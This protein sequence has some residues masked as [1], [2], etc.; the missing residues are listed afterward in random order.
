MSPYQ[1]A[2]EEGS[3]RV[4]MP[5]S[6]QLVFERFDVPWTDYVG[7][8]A[9]IAPTEEKAEEVKAPAVEGLEFAKAASAG[10]INDWFWNLPADRFELHPDWIHRLELSMAPD[11]VAGFEACIEP[12]DLPRVRRTIR[13][14][15]A[16]GARSFVVRFSLCST[17]G[18]VLP[19]ECFGQVLRSSEGGEPE[20]LGGRLRPLTGGWEST[21]VP[22][23]PVAAELPSSGNPLWSGTR[24][25]LFVDHDQSILRL[26]RVQLRCLGYAA[27]T[28]SSAEE[29]LAHVD[30][31]HFDAVVADERLPGM[32]GR[33]L[34]IH[35]ARR[36]SPPVLV[37]TS[38]F[39]GNGGGEM[40][41]VEGVLEKPYD[42]QDLARVLVR[43]FSCSPGHGIE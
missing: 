33:G 23:D 11:G 14:H 40:E 19:C 25:V 28:C 20:L 32:G 27:T 43:A 38:G 18:H 9:Q 3:A 37:L 15:L 8:S 41:G 12:R 13:D 6:S 26:A 29:A 36:D 1:R 21:R 34:A 17:A 39:A 35:L 10:T 5:R 2:L 31:R 22:S 24:R 4:P 16:R 7:V 30:A 42:L